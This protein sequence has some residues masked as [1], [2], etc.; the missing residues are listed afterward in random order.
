MFDLN[1]ANT[2]DNCDKHLA[3]IHGLSK[4]PVCDRCLDVT[5]LRTCDCHESRDCQ[6]SHWREGH[7]EECAELLRV[8]E[9]SESYGSIVVAQRRSIIRWSKKNR[10]I[11]N[12]GS[13]FA[14]EVGTTEDK[15][16]RCSPL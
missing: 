11:L 4:E 14:L 15:S 5:T 10:A 12:A 3:A 9:L 7:K 13:V 1:L 2:C 8:A 16:R 6:K